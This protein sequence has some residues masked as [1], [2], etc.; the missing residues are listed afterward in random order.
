MEYN[1]YL[2]TAVAGCTMLG[3]TVV[4]Q[5]LGLDADVDA[6]IDGG[7]DLDGADV[8]GHGNFFFGVLSLKALVAFLG[9]FGLTGLILM[10]QGN[11]APMMRAL[12]ATLVG[13]AVMFVVA[14]LMRG[15]AN[16]GASGSL[17]IE[18]AVGRDAMVYLT[19]PASGDGLG[20]VTVEL[21]GRT[22]ELAA[23]TDGES[24][25]TGRRVRILESVGN[26]VVKV[27]S[28]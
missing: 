4:L 5:L 21:Q 22:V 11:M 27:A 14:W 17:R 23:V 12:L 3:I 28:V 2:W 9:A 10:K 13:V 16:L 24:I 18:G 7:A 6:E 26:E 19:V 20:K 15:I 8:D 1:I 25:P